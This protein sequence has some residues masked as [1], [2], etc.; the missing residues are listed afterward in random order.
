[1]GSCNRAK[2]LQAKKG[3]EQMTFF[4]LLSISLTLEGG[5]NFEQ[6]YASAKECGDALPAIYYEYYP[7]FPD[8]MGQ[9]LQTDKVSSITIKP[10]LRPE[11][12]E[13]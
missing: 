7:H 11:G 5:S 3:I 10:K 9:C 12:L 1:M 8:A 6:M 13:L 2:A 4:T